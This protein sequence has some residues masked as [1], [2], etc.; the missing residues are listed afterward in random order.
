MWPSTGDWKKTGDFLRGGASP[1][2]LWISE[3]MMCKTG[4]ATRNATKANTDNAVRTVDQVVHEF[5]HSIDYNYGLSEAMK[6][7]SP[8]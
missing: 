1:D 4:V 3:Q 8:T 5:G 2:F 7:F 6:P